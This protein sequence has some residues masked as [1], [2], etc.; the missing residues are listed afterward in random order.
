MEE[1]DLLLYLTDKVLNSKMEVGRLAL[2]SMQ[3]RLL[4]M[5]QNNSFNHLRYC[6][7]KVLL[8]VISDLELRQMKPQRRKEHKMSENSQSREVF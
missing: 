5:P 7:L 2:S 8:K 4:Q 6:Q 1:E 3:L